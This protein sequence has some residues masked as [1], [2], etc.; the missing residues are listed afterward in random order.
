MGPLRDGPARDIGP[1]LRP[2]S[3]D[4]YHT[5]IAFVR[6]VC[7]CKKRWHVEISRETER[8]SER[9]R[10]KCCICMRALGL[11]MCVFQDLIFM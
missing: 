8:V 3:Y 9:E 2:G 4:P 10:E 11:V 1:L 7:M 6:D 5:G